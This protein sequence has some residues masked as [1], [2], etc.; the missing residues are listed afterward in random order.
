MD[1][2]SVSAQDEPLIREFTEL[3][4]RL[5]RGAPQWVPGFRGG[6]RRFLQRRHPFFEH[7]DAR[8]FLAR[9]DGRTV[10]RLTVFENRQ[11]NDYH[12]RRCAR[13]H[14]FEVEEDPEP[15]RRLFEAAAEW[16]AGRGL[17]ELVGPYGFSGFD[18]AGLL[19][20]G[21]E[22]RAAMTMMGWHPPYYRRLLE[23]LGF[24]KVT[25]LYS[26]R[27]DRRTYRL[28]DK[29]RRVA[30]LALKRGGFRVP[31]FRS[32]REIRRFAGPVGRVFNEAF[33]THPDFTPLTEG[34]ISRL[35]D[36]LL[37]ATY[38][39]L[40]KILFH[41]DEVAGFLLAFPD[42][43][44]ALQRA[45]GRLAPPALLD[46]LA[47][48]RRARTLII[49]GAGILPRFQKLGGNALL[50]HEIVRT[51]MD[52]RYEAGEMVQIAE[53]T[54]LMIRDMKTLGGQVHKVHRVYRLAL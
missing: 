7:S 16:A 10:G 1:I 31:V 19:V 2:H 30:E 43:S 48:K 36:E 23:G 39:H 32:A 25:D 15:A 18:G 45:R 5:H 49:N 17:D 24:R 26:A 38:P 35:A 44:A 42:L 20:E 40:M 4:F 46:L 21:F 27:L 13:F 11:F 41:R 6:L 50:Y 34:E 28:P 51:V 29:V 14:H 52:S 22:H 47:E 37:Q 9:R 12:G 54:D 3:P 8:F 33:T 53:T